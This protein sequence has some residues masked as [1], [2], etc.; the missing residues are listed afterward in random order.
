MLDATAAEYRTNKVNKKVETTKKATTNIS[1][2]T[3][4]SFV[5]LV[6]M[7]AHNCCGY[8]YVL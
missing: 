7:C 6:Y 3:I 4:S 1:K 2:P 5:D 8:C